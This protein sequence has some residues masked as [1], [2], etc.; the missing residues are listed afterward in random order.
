MVIAN[1]TIIIPNYFNF[2]LKKKIYIFS[3]NQSFLRKK[4]K[5]MLFANVEKSSILRRWEFN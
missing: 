1:F 2:H 4:V 3:S 5:L